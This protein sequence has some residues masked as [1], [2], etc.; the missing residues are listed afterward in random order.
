MKIIP[1]RDLVLIH[2][3]KPKKESALGILL[4]EDWKTLSPMATVV[5]VGPEVEGVKEGDRVSFNQ[6]G[7]FRLDD[8]QKLITQKHILA[9]INETN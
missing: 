3:D 1:L 6:Y 4:V 2:P 9:I 7:A 5:S 8:E